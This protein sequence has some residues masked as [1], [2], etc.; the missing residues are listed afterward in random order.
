[1]KTIEKL[2]VICFDMSFVLFPGQNEHIDEKIGF[3]EEVL[4][5]TYL[6]QLYEN[7]SQACLLLLD[8]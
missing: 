8:Y 4:N 1:M 5:V 3:P 6:T 2:H 7:V